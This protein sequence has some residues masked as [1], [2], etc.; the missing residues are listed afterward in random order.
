M[1]PVRAERMNNDRMGA[2]GMRNKGLRGEE[3][4][5]KGARWIEAVD[6]ASCKRF[7]SPSSCL[8]LVCLQLASFL[9]LC[10]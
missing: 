9:I 4:R 2:E 8:L 10:S 5:A 7:E 6:I 3:I 1:K